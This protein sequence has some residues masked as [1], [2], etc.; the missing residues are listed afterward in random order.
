MDK[1]METRLNYLIANTIWNQ[2]SDEEIQD[3]VLASLESSRM[4]SPWGYELDQMDLKQNPEKAKEAADYFLS[5]YQKM[6]QTILD[7]PSFILNNENPEENWKQLLSPES[8]TAR[9]IEETI[10]KMAEEDPSL[11]ENLQMY[12]ENQIKEQIQNGNKALEMGYLFAKEPFS[13]ENRAFM[14]ESYENTDFLDYNLLPSVRNAANA[15]TNEPDANPDWLNEPE[16][17]SK[18]GR[19]YIEEPE[20]AEYQLKAVLEEEIKKQEAILKE[21]ESQKWKHMDEDLDFT[22]EPELPDYNKDLFVSLTS[23][24]LQV[25]FAES[26]KKLQDDDYR[27]DPERYVERLMKMQL[28]ESHDL[29]SDKAMIEAF[30]QEKLR[31]FHL[32][33]NMELMKQLD[34]E[35]EYF[36]QTLGQ[37]E[38]RKEIL[39]YQID[40]LNQMTK[41]SPAYEEI[42]SRH[43]SPG[44]YF[45]EKGKQDWQALQTKQVQNEKINIISDMYRCFDG[46]MNSEPERVMDILDK[47]RKQSNDF[48]EVLGKL[49]RREEEK[50]KKY[51]EDEKLRFQI[52]DGIR[53]NAKNC[54][55]EQA[56]N[57]NERQFNRHVSEE[58]LFGGISEHNENLKTV[59][60]NLSKS[61]RKG[62]FGEKKENSREYDTMVEALD[63]LLEDPIRKKPTPKQKE[64]IRQAYRLCQDYVTLRTGAKT[65]EG[66][67]RLNQANEAIKILEE[68]YPNVKKEKRAGTQNRQKISFQDLEQESG[69]DRGRVAVHREVSREREPGRERKR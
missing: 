58:E 27:N 59:V 40:A 30:E 12:L 3:E 42:E 51:E 19:L 10:R 33:P 56:Q 37:E 62:I 64:D 55:E 45:Y 20:K 6:G 39:N 48:V 28:L 5:L 67:K 68:M 35:K 4:E 47:A 1:N 53:Y 32:T 11:K 43:N 66:K 14:K 25:Y 46:S 8:L 44:S 2:V 61:V 36:Y 7:N 17:Y 13:P 65:S 50:Q 34:S 31:I 23:E 38:G 63:A 41:G 69:R 22:E 9:A 52:L 54:L 16:A 60:D 24:T 18:I 26:L 15:L 49:D 29:I 57:E 21:Q